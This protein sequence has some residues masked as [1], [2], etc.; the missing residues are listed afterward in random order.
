MNTP[1]VRGAFER[2]S[3]T[4]PQPPA[5]GFTNRRPPIKYNGAIPGTNIIGGGRYQ[6]LKNRLISYGLSEDV[7]DELIAQQRS[8]VTGVVLLFFSKEGLPILCIGCP[9]AWWIFFARDLMES[10]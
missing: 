5:K 2:T 7:V 3:E 4:I 1:S 6:K 10:K 9:T 8:S